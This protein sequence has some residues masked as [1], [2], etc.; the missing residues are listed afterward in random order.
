MC[1]I[2]GACADLTRSVARTVFEIL[3]D[4]A[5]GMD[6]LKD[7]PVVSMEDPDL[8][9]SL[10]Q[11]IVTIGSLSGQFAMC[12]TDRLI[13]VS[14]AP[15]SI[16]FAFASGSKVNHNAVVA[17]TQ[18]HKRR[19]DPVVAHATADGN[20]AMRGG[21]AVVVVKVKQAIRA[22]DHLGRTCRQIHRGFSNIGRHESF[23]S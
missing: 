5:I 21:V 10:G 11:T 8:A 3:G 20:R 16:D 9:A 17:C 23:L 1:A 18:A 12:V 4:R 13:V 14:N 2:V 15:E 6:G 19:S 7:G 22:C